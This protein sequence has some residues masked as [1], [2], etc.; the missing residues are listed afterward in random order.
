MLHKFL[1][2]IEQ[3]SP[4]KR[5]NFP[6]NV[7]PFSPQKMQDFPPIVDNFPPILSSSPRALQGFSFPDGR[8]F[9]WDPGEFFQSIPGGFSFSIE[10]FSLDID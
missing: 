4:Q 1:L 7:E 5:K 3:F 6:L 10:R 2:N 9:L 8:I